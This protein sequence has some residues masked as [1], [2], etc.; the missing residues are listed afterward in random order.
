MSDRQILIDH[1]GRWIEITDPTGMVSLD[2]TDDEFAELEERLER[3]ED[4]DDVC[5]TFES[6]PVMV[7]QVF[8]QAVEDFGEGD[9]LVEE[10]QE[11]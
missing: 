5:E 3:G 4:L 11:I 8:I 9:D 6:K 7:D 1:D 10:S 2:L